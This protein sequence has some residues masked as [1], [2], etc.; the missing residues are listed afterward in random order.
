MKTC[1]KCGFSGKDELFR[2]GRN[3]CNKCVAEYQKEYREKTAER[4][5]KYQKEYRIKNKQRLSEKHK[6]YREENKEKISEQ[7]KKHREEHKQQISERRKKHYDR[8]K[9]HV[10]EYQKV[11]Y[12]TPTG[13]ITKH[14]SESKRRNLGHLPIN[15]WFE[16]CEG[17]HLRYSKNPDEQDN[18]ITLYIP[19]K[20]HRSIHHNGN[21]GKNMKEI[22]VAALEW[23]FETTPE[24][25]RNPKAVRLYWNYCTFPEPKWSNNTS[26]T[27]ELPSL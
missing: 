22:N 2:K 13:K 4:L 9:D 14:K 23:Y 20:L 27:S 19:R 17:H 25:E 24:E 11:Y 3:I 18:D 6:I 12:K 5:S 26:P 21:T 15:S 1:S 7:R 8:Y 16:G 10:S